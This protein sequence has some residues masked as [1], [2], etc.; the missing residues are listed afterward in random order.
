MLRMNAIGGVLTQ[1]VQLINVTAPNFQAAINSGQAFVDFA[2]CFNVPEDAAG[3]GG[4]VSLRFYNTLGVTPP[5]SAIGLNVSSNP[6]LDGLRNTWQMISINP[7]QVPVG[8]LRIDAEVGFNNPRLNGLAGLVDAASL[9]LQIVPE[10]A[11]AALAFFGLAVSAGGVYRR[12]RKIS[13]IKK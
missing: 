6:S 5:A 13:G 2:A 11:S 12:C 8:T 1:A 3:A 9:N 7:V 10:P 4:Y